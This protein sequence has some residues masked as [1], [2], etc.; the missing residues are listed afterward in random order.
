MATQ[1]IEITQGGWQDLETL[2][3][4]TLT[5]GNN[6]TLTILSNGMNEVCISDTTPSATFKG[7]PVDNSENFGFTYSG[8]KI[9]VK[10]STLRP[11]VAYVVFS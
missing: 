4:L 7:H 11:N 10:L 9:W 5:N 3:G 6:Y 8:E 1:N 2:G